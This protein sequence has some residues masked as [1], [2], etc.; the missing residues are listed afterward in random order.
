MSRPVC[1]CL[2]AYGLAGILLISGCSADK[3]GMPSATLASSGTNSTTT[4][5]QTGT[6]TVTPTGTTTVTPPPLLPAT[7]KNLYVVQAAHNPISTLVFPLKAGAG[8]PPFYEIP[9]SQVAVDGAGNIYVLNQD[10]YP[11]F[12]VHSINVYAATSPTGTPIRSLPV[13]PGTKIADASALAVS[14]AGEIY[15]YDGTGIAVF[16]ATATGDADPVRYIQGVATSAGPGKIWA[17][18]MTV[19]DAG[20]LYVAGNGYIPIVVYGP[21]DTGPVAPMRAIA[22]DQTSMASACQG[23][24]MVGMTANDAGEIYVLYV[25][26]PTRTTSDTPVTLYKFGAGAN[27]NVAPEKSLTLQSPHFATGLALDSAG[28]IYVSTG[29]AVFEYAAGASG[30]ATPSNT[31]TSKLLGR[32]PP[33]P[34]E[35]D[36]FDPSGTIVLH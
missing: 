14:K 22:G 35:D 1:L 17:L 12:T 24:G 26:Y 19:D 36:W 4:V 31:L 6:T 11:T 29:D 7:Q 8:S 33:P 34:G 25:C 5:T 28:N 27:G 30:A 15:V 21:K 9:G 2:S 32:M 23:Y 13:G 18:Y 20:N 3:G 16:D 10:S